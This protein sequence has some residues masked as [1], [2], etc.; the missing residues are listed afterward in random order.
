MCLI[1]FFAVKYTYIFNLRLNKENRCN[2][3]HKSE[4]NISKMN[5][6]STKNV[7]E[8]LSQSI[9]NSD[10]I[11]LK[12]GNK[13]C[14]SACPNNSNDI[15][16]N[17]KKKNNNAITITN[18][19]TKN[20]EIQNSQVSAN[21]ISSDLQTKNNANQKNVTKSSELKSIIEKTDETNDNLLIA[22]LANKP[23]SSRRCA[24]CSR[25]DKLNCKK[26]L[27]TYMEHLVRDD[28]IRNF[29]L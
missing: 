5:N 15:N 14:L 21:P 27:S 7:K 22:F 3:Q 1:Q 4:S 26:Q 10:G 18:N 24:I 2:H 25:L 20:S 17:L 29:L 9:K 16:D 28:Y 8:T 12:K 13:K 19:I 6:L 11:K 23:V